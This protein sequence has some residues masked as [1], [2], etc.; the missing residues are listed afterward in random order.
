MDGISNREIIILCVRLYLRY[1]LSLRDL[2]GMMAKRRSSLAHTTILRRVRR[3]TP[4]FVKRWNR[5]ATPAGSLVACR[6][7]LAEGSG[8]VGLPV[9][10]GG[11]GLARR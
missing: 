8:Q 5:F 3:Y 11:I 1:K 6:R 10:G 7:D 2:V 9:S 4:E